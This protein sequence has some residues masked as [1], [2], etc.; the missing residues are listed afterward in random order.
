MAD[1]RFVHASPGTPAVDVGLVSGSTFTPVFKDVSFGK[2]AA[3]G[4]GIDANG[5]LATT[6]LSGVTLGAA[7]TG[8]TNVVKSVSG[9]SAPAGA[10]V[11]AFAIGGKTG[12]T[13]NPLQVLLCVDSA[14][15]S[16]VLTSCAAM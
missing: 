14:A 3:A 6:P 7:P 13:T 2:F 12:A 1:V 16:G 11:S 5:Y 10:I 15:A 8:T 4:S 9:V